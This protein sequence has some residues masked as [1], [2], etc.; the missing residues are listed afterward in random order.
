MY[1]WYDLNY[2]ENIQRMKPTILFG[3]TPPTKQIQLKVKHMIIKQWIFI[4][5]LWNN[6]IK[7]HYVHGV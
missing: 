1:I 4:V 6:R 3:P 5:I 7:Q 2:C